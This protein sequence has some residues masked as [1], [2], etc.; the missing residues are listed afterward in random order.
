MAV[1]YLEPS[2][3]DCSRA[4]A[5]GGSANHERV[6]ILQRLVH[7]P[8]LAW[9]LAQAA[10]PHLDAVENNDIFVAIGAGETFA[11]MAKLLKAVAIKRIPLEPDLARRSVSWLHAYAGH[12]D[13]RYLRRL[14][15]GFVI[16]YAI[17]F[18]ATVRA[19]RLPTATKSRTVA[20]TS[21]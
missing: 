3:S 6:V 5:F 2:I 12:D 19:N 15:E 8:S 1:T 13:E 18:P 17:R 10:K 4:P 16:P 7:E 11:A 20:L 9:A 14:I 21:P